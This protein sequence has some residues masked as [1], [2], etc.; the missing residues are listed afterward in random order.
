MPAE[1]EAEWQRFHDAT[2]STLDLLT[3]WDFVIYSVKGT[4]QQTAFVQLLALDEGDLVAEVSVRKKRWF[5]SKLHKEQEGQ[6]RALGWEPPI[7]GYG[8]GHYQRGWSSDKRALRTDGRL[9]IS[10]AEKH[11]A[12]SLLVRTLREFFGV[13][14]PRELQVT[15]DNSRSPRG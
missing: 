8:V 14:D 15:Q 6:I 5:S 13:R 3:T 12:A 2:M 4:P 11:D 10:L 7:E 1:H 9:G